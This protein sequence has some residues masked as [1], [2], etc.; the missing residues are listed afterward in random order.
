MKS[1][2]SGT[3]PKCKEKWSHIHRNDPTWECSRLYCGSCNTFIK[4]WGK[5]NKELGNY[6][7]EEDV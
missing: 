7:G 2:S 3:C 6:R 4:D 5:P 1:V